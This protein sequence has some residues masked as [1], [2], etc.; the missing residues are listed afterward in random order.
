M[1]AYNV[2]K[3]APIPNSQSVI[4]YG[5]ARFTILTS[6]L[7]RIEYDPEGPF[8]DRP[9]QVFWYRAQPTPQYDVKK[10]SS[11]VNIETNDLILHYELGKRF[12]QASPSIFIKK[13]NTYWR[14]GDA[15]NTNLKG[16][17]RTLDQSNG[18]EEL[19]NGLIS[20]SGWSLYD[21]SK[22]LVFNS[23]GW[24]EHRGKPKQYQD[25]YFFG[26]GHDY[27]SCIKDFQKVSGEVP[28]IPRW[29][30]GNWWSRYW[31][32]PQSE[33]LALMDSFNEH[34]IPI[35]VCVVDMDWHITKTCN[36]SS[37]WTG[38]TWNKVLFPDPDG[39]IQSL[40]QKGLKTA[41]NL[42]PAEGVHPHEEMYP[43]M[44][45]RMGIDPSSQ[46]PVKFDI[47]NPDFV[48]AYFE[49]LHHP[50]EDKGVDF[51]WIDWQQGAKTELKNLDPLFWLNHLHAYDRTRDDKK[52]PFIFSRWPGL[53]GHRYPIGFSG[54]TCAT[55]ESLDFQPYF[56]ATASNVA[57][58]WW[59]HD[60]GGHMGGEREAELYLRWVQFGVFSPILRLH[61][62]NEPIQ[63]RL[64]WGY[65]LE[66]EKCARKALQ[67]RHK[68][69]PYIYTAA[70]EN[71]NTGVPLILPMY[72]R[73]PNALEAYQ[74][75]KQY[76]FGSELLVAPFTSLADP[77]TKQSR[78]RIWLPDGDWF[79]FFTGEYYSGD[80]WYSFYGG[81]D[82][83]PVLARAGAIVPLDNGGV[84]NT[85]EN[86]QSLEL[87]L[88][89]G[90]NNSFE[91]FEDDGESLAYQKG[92]Y[93]IIEFEQQWKPDKLT[94]IIHPVDG[95]IGHLPKIRSYTLKIL[96]INEP[97]F[98]KLIINGKERQLSSAY[99]ETTAVLQFAPFDCTIETSAQLILGL[100]NGLMSKRDR[101]L[102]KVK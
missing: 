38:Y 34:N 101:E 73:N 53:G 51:W 80:S 84:S 25:L 3:F 42:H 6:R 37:G 63:E 77:H 60:I 7:I 22:S 41:L 72:Y 66:T 36:S 90:A 85:T 98:I 83:I 4:A 44:A 47:T 54:D 49:V 28:L 10:S 35:S 102:D 78:Q 33:L 23:D 76:Y 93:S 40:H 65:D 14:Y 8:D 96:G 82:D 43:Q 97:T 88:F 18:A 68:L 87:L 21:D 95:Q 58:G 9:S 29:A 39:F 71:T 13:E 50:Y 59:S 99:N 62:T 100:E 45:E 94:F 86:P 48:S 55:W 32:Y 67:L 81:N 69:I 24:L 61:S 15:N 31:A 12:S 56:T 11:E 5:N 27:L 52:R 79:N 75:P 2:P 26:Y 92:N 30:L 19:D 74:C 91:L 70:W 89:P 20:L 17:I 64:P 46:E 1:Y 16:T 57:F